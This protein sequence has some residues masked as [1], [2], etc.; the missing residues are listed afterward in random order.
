M[1]V[2][3]SCFEAITPAI[4]YDCWVQD[5]ELSDD[6]AIESGLGEDSVEDGLITHLHV[7]NARPQA[8]NIGSS[9]QGTKIAVVQNP[10]DRRETSVNAVELEYL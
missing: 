5:M 2:R 7:T 1:R 10:T 4:G 9:L 6:P 3:R 8:P